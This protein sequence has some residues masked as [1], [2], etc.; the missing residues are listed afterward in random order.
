MG[1]Q[2]Y[3]PM[4]T[5]PL[6]GTVI[7]VL[8]GSRK[9][10][11][12]YWDYKDN[13][14]HYWHAPKETCLPSYWTAIPADPPSDYLPALK[15][16][17]DEEMFIREVEHGV[18]MD[19][20]KEDGKDA[21]LSAKDRAKSV[22]SPEE[23]VA[24]QKAAEIHAQE[25]S[26]RDEYPKNAAY[27]ANKAQTNQPPFVPKTEA[28]VITPAKVEAKKEVVKKKSSPDETEVLVKDSGKDEF[29]PYKA[30]QTISKSQ[31]PKKT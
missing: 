23:N 28:P 13:S 25:L 3:K 1:V 30:D 7:L 11:T 26:Q 6:D 15:T 10:R 21:P 2:D 29:V 19:K 17:E 27:Y 4:S 16:L 12:A 22:P 8:A 14:W 9:P 5:A 18:L 20:I 24:A 31:A